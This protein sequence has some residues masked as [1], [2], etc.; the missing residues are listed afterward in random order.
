MPAATPLPRGPSV[1]TLYSAADLL[2]APG[3]PVCRYAAEAS[4]R[5]LHWFALEGH[6]Q[7]ATITSLRA[8]LGMCPAHTRRLMNQPGAPVRLTAVYRYVVT[9]AGDRLA[10]RDARQA[11]C[12]GCEHDGAAAGRALDTLTEDLS[13]PP[14]LD[15]LREL[16]GLCLPHLAA[17][18]STGRPRLVAPLVQTM[19][20]AIAACGTR[21]DWLAGT[22]P[23]AGN[24]A[25]LRAAVPSGRPP[26]PVACW[27][28]LT[29]A[30]AERDALARQLGQAGGGPDPALALCP[31]HLADASAAAGGRGVRPL[32]AWQAQ[33]L[34]LRM[35]AGSARW[36]RLRRLGGGLPD[37]CAVC[38]ARQ[39]AA[40]R[41][42]TGPPGESHDPAA[43][44]A[45]CIR[46]H[47]ALR[48]ADPRGARQL[49]RRAI[50]QAD[51]LAAELADAFDRS[52]RA[53]SH[54]APAPGST[55]W[56]RAAAFLDG[57]VFGG[58]S[59]PL[60][61]GSVRD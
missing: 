7:P 53:R 30:L 26:G 49:A 39:T 44:A 56:Q 11:A 32:L 8:S 18:S 33:C 29:G 14:V 1:L 5:Y 27:P 54:G 59:R 60:P 46:H 47:L 45:L 3:C 12:P 22:D 21:C 13:D 16:G 43:T 52:A 24:R 20:A 4:D 17:A 34:T 10:G 51:Q 25:A 6:S 35:H 31:G 19:Q 37:E 36:M 61:A 48:A 41:A 28:C 38:H 58:W 15:R 23:D 40:R 9:A 42:L 55:A 57:S 50:E 2:T